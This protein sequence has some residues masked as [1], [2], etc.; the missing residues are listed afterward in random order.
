MSRRYEITTTEW[1]RIKDLLPPER[2]GKKGR[3]RKDNR[4]MLNAMLWIVRSGCQWR[5]L[6]EY[7]GSW[8]SVYSRFRKWEKDGIFEA[9]FKEE[10]YSLRRA[11]VVLNDDRRPDLIRNLEFPGKV[12]HK[13]KHDA[14]GRQTATWQTNFTAQVG[15]PATRIAYDQLGRAIARIDQ[16]GNTTTTTYSPDGRTVSVHNPNTS[17]RI[18]TRSA[19]GSALSITGTAVTPEFHTYGM[20]W[21]KSGYTFYVDG[22][23]CRNTDFGLSNGEEYVLLSNFMRDFKTQTIDGDSADFVVDYVRVYQT[24]G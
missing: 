24:K 9:I 20:K 7:Y 2:S 3:P 5:E 19:S 10:K 22:K 21:T 18:T 1:N 6:P 15:L 16:L 8:Q 14:L 17:T 12:L 13:R 4:N 23:E 11:A